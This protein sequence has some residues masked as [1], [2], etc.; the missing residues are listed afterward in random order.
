[1]T[2]A[3]QSQQ[4]P[5][6][7]I[8]Q[9]DAILPDT[10]LRQASR[11]VFFAGDHI[12]PSEKYSTPSRFMGGVELDMFLTLKE[13]GKELYARP[14]LYNT[15]GM[16][17]RCGITQ[18]KTHYLDVNP[19]MVAPGDR[20]DSSKYVPGYVKENGRRNHVTGQYEDVTVT[21]HLYRPFYPG[22][23]IES[24]TRPSQGLRPGGIV[25]IAALQGKGWDEQ[26]AA[27]LHFFPNWE[28]LQTE[29]D[30]FPQTLK[31][32]RD[33]IA[34]KITGASL[35]LQSIGRDMLRSCDEFRLWGLR[36]IKAWRQVVKFADANVDTPIQG[37]NELAEM[38][39]DLLQVNRE[40]TLGQTQNAY[41]GE[42]ATQIGQAIATA[43]AQGM[44]PQQ[45]A[46]VAGDPLAGMVEADATP[47]IV[48]GEGN[49][50]ADQTDDADKTGTMEVER[51]HEKIEGH[52][53]WRT[54]GDETELKF[55]SDTPGPVSGEIKVGQK[56]TVDADGREGLVTWKGPN[57]KIKLSFEGGGTLTLDKSEVTAK[58]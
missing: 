18:L 4:Q 36:Y 12:S 28:R 33:G 46:Q 31:E 34:A 16:L 42:I 38:L 37:Y 52:T 19:N 45:A 30:S 40:D 29:Q 56:V 39:F 58:N 27:Q 13:T 21:G 15:G 55:R 17:Y 9:S 8:P 22:D 53:D 1:M 7:M 47:G 6:P 26:I 23:E 20:E 49:L 5:H 54:N 51:R 25:E 14:D 43:I 41:V 57:D 32:L 3:A 44:S 10:K 24:L 35:H 11:F 2:P 48:I 50:A